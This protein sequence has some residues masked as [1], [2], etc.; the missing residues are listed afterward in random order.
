MRYSGAAVAGMI[1]CLPLGGWGGPS[2]REGKGQ[3]RVGQGNQAMEVFTYRPKNF[4]NGPLFIVF[5]GMKRNAEDYRDYA[6]PLAQRHG[7]MVAAPLFD[8]DQFPSLSYTRGEVL[9]ENGRGLPRA[10]WSFTRGAQMI[11]KLL[12]REG[13]PPSD[14][15]LIGHSAGGQFLVR[16]VLLEE[17]VEARKIVAANPGSYVFPRADWDWPYGLG[18]LPDPYAGEAAVRRF[19]AAPLTIYLGQADTSSSVEAGNFDA[20]PEANR[21]GAHRLERGR[22]FFAYGQNLAREKNWP[23][24]WTKVEVPGIAHEGRLMLEHAKL[25]QILDVANKTP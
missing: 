15:Y 3:V 24:G 9:D 4:S 7:A 13:I 11:R 19:L 8:K 20:S 25:D 23:F 2:D 5:H 1:L 14:S 18:N 12:A 17:K 21:Q 22:N 6:I 10:G 16:L